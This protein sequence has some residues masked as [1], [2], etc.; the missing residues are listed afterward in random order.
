[1][2]FKK[3]VWMIPYQMMRTLHIYVPDEVQSSKQRY[4]VFYMYDGHNLFDDAEATYGKSWGLKEYLDGQKEKRIIVGIECNHE[5]NQRIVEYCPYTF[6]DHRL[7]TIVGSG[8]QMMEWVVQE[9]KPLIDQELPTL[10]DRNHTWIGGSSMGGLMALY[11]ITYHNAVFSR[12]ACLSP[13]LGPVR[14]QIAQD[15][16]LLLQ[17]DTY[18]YLSWGSNESRSKRGFTYMSKVNIEI[19]NLLYQQ[20]IHL[21]LNLVPGGQHWEA[22]WEKEIPTFF[23]FFKQ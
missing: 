8:K 21:R 5:G 10:P 9:L 6:Y 13:F 12:A 22:S 15:C 18:I 2:I 3:E 19:A 11:S 1:M 16:Q 20:D 23:Q 17:T 14:K 4:P 7:G